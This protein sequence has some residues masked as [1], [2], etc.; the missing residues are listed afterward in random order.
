MPS[1]CSVRVML[2][3]GWPDHG[4]GR[5]AAFRKDFALLQAVKKRRSPTA[6]HWPASIL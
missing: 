4:A 3:Y 6:G 2:S 5:Q 1:C